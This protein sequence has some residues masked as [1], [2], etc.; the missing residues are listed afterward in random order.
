ME[1]IKSKKLDKC[2]G[3]AV[4]RC[5]DVWLSTLLAARQ[6]TDLVTA[7]LTGDW[8]WQTMTNE[9]FYFFHCFPLM[10]TGCIFN[11]AVSTWATWMRH[12]SII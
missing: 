6:T 11:H 4:D 3:I 1:S 7:N 12:W 9:L 5:K 10:T 2:Q 8:A